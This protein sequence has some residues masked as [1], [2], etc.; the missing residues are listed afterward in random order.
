M[1][2]SILRYRAWSLLFTRWQGY[3]PLTAGIWETGPVWEGWIQDGNRLGRQWGWKGRLVLERQDGCRERSGKVQDWARLGFNPVLRSKSWRRSRGRQRP[4]GGGEG[5]KVEV[6]VLCH[7]ELNF[8]DT[9]EL[10]H[11]ASSNA[12]E[13]IAEPH[14]CVCWK[15]S[16][17]DHTC[18]YCWWEMDFLHLTKALLSWY[19]SDPINDCKLIWAMASVWK[20]QLMRERCTQGVTGGWR[21]GLCRAQWS[22]SVIF[23]KDGIFIYFSPFSFWDDTKE[24]KI[25]PFLPPNQKWMLQLCKQ[26]P[27]WF[28]WE[29]GPS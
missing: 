29:K 27:P 26:H 4:A 5:G 14:R 19:E 20:V 28:V 13:S 11:P 12:R 8:W 18:N 3:L 23:C 25:T 7:L 9:F 10:T 15:G 17:S 24:E 2:A 21:R 1:G 22:L 16:P 6:Y